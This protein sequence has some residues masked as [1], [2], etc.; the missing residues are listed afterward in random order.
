MLYAYNDI[1]I[2]IA[3]HNLTCKPS[4]HT[5]WDIIDIYIYI[6]IYIYTLMGY[7][8]Y[9]SYNNSGKRWYRTD[10]FHDGN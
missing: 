2:Y 3:Q 8:G 4:T 5:S 1:Y 6:H 10:I 9:I 7:R